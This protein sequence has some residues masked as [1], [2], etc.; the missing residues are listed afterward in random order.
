MS[1]ETA[2]KVAASIPYRGR[3]KQRVA[4]VVTD[5]RGRILSI[6]QNSYT[7]THPLQAHYA[8]K[9]NDPLAICLHAE[10]SA[11][12]LL[13]DNEKKKAHKIFVA[14]VMK[15]G[16]TGLAAPCP[17]CQ[18]AIKDFNIKSVEYTL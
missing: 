2:T 15:D 6:G 3:N 17:I 8:E 11:L 9:V 5:K 4:A 13:S 1:I 12:S 7:K 14:R 16:S 18:A 10:I